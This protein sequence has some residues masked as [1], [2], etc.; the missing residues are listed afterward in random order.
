MKDIAEYLAA[1]PESRRLLLDTMHSLIIRLYPEASVDMRYK[2]PTYHVGDGWVAI[3]NQKNYVSL[4]T[5]GA[6][7]LAQFRKKHPKIKTGKG[8]IN[9]K[10]TDELPMTDVEAVV[11]HAIEHSKA[12]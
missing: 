4:Y 11:R 12:H 5:C 8:C 10:P 7:H 1:V 2:M 6:H 9:F 3:A